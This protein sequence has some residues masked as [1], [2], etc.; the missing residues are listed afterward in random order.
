MDNKIVEAQDILKAFKLP[1]PQQNKVSALTLLALCDIKPND[2][3]G[4][5]K[6]VTK[7]LSTDLMEFVS[8]YYFEYK[9][10]S[11]ES[12]RNNALNP[13][14]EIGLVDKNPDDPNLHPHSP[15]TNYAINSLALSTIRKY[16][17]EE[18]EVALDNYLRY[19]EFSHLALSPDIQIRT[20][21]VNSFKSIAEDK[22]E[23]GRFNVFIGANGC[24]KTNILEALATVGAERVNDVTFEGLYS[25]G[26]RVARPDLMLSS[27]LS[28]E[29]QNSIEIALQIVQEGREE[30]HKCS[31]TPDS[32]KDIYTKW[33]NLNEEED[34]GQ[35]ILERFTELTSQRPGLTGSEL[36]ALVNETIKDKPL[37]KTNKF[38]SLLSE[39][40]IF[41]LNTKSLRGIT[42]AESKKTPLGING[43]GLDLLIATFTK[44]ERAQ[45]NNALKFFDWLDEI[46]ADREDKFK[47]TG[48]KPARSKSTLYFRDKYMQNENSVFS[49]EN[50]NEGVLHVIFYLALFISTKTPRLFAID[51]IETSLNPLLCSSLIPELVKLTKETK[52]QVLI[53]THNPAILDGLNLLDDE[54]RLFEVFRDSK[55]RTKTRRIVFKKDL[56]DKKF[57]LSELWLKG[58][59]GAIPKPF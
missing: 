10:G 49:A 46:I 1:E 52:K 59:M 40:S 5:A 43:E 56:S 20:L 53:T 25:R 37:R 31:L 35:L 30:L 24:G 38:D 32:V 54:Q 18:W 27:F 22:I 6:R 29:Q 17:T 21:F 3:W 8:A 23:L 15:K 11:R 14:V 2:D 48:L 44:T 36:L 51:N 45:L 9:S 19:R 55:G 34:Y 28:E 12:F 41:D 4:K 33:V 16:K 58:V 50:S 26:V 42:P 57:K 47:L 13:F 39:Y 7:S